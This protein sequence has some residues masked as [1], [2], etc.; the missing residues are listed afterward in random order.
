MCIKDLEI[1]MFV[2]DFAVY[3]Y[4][5]PKQDMPVYFLDGGSIFVEAFC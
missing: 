2:N 5:C 1:E 4:W 3:R